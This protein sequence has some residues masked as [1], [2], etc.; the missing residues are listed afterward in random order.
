MKLL[1]RILLAVVIIIAIPFVAAIFVKKDYQIEREILIYAPA[2]EIFDFIRYLENQDSF[3]K[4]GSMDPDMI[5][6]YRGV[7]GTVGAIS[8][9]ESE[10][11]NVGKGEQEITSIVDGERIEYEL[12]FIE[13]FQSTSQAWMTTTPVDESTTLVQWGFKGRMPYP[14]NL[15][16]LLM[17][18]DKMLGDD[19]QHGL[20]NLKKQMENN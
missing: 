12:R 13:P 2:Y 3:S 7:D 6:T 11:R 14:M 15:M 1:K 18:F 20:D 19:L 9:W 5:Q 17:N 4:W 10:D 16:L 8:A